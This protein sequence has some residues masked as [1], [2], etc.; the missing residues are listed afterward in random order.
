MKVTT[1]ALALT[2]LGAALPAQAATYSGIAGAPGVVWI[3]AG[4]PAPLADASIRQTAKAF[5]PELLVVT[6]GT[7]VRFPN[8]D[9]FF[10]SVYSDSP[11]NPFDL[12]LYD[13]GPGKSVVF[14]NTGVVDVRCHVHG[15]MHATIVVVDGPYAVTTRAGERFRFDG[16]PP[17][18]H[19]LH[20]WTDGT[21]VATTYI[22]VK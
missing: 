19:A 11:S 21:K 8:D 3:T 20:V 4:T 15:T 9:R 2:M 5:V 6:P 22:V 14:E 10:H 13:N 12:G 1:L 7:A 16:L 18:P 17:G